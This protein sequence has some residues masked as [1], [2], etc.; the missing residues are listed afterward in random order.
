MERHDAI[1]K[2]EISDVATHGGDGASKLMSENS[3]ALD[4]GECAGAIQDV[5]V[6]DGAGGNLDD[7]FVR[8]RL[9]NDMVGCEY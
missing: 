8:G 2:L 1:T 6:G 4:E 7:N 9:T 5:S 3:V